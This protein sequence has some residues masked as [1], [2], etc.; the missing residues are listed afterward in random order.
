[1]HIQKK[2]TYVEPRV[3]ELALIEMTH[4]CNGSDSKNPD[5]GID[6]GS[7]DTEEEPD[8]IPTPDASGRVWGD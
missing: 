7:T 3:E 1:M 4:L 8:I 6:N 2:K 5:E